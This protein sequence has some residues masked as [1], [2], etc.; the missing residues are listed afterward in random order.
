LL[1]AEN[2]KEEEKNGFILAIRWKW[3]MA[4][5]AEIE[6]RQKRDVKHLSGKGI[7]RWKDT[8]EFT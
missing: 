6:N 2:E 1:Y 8:S 7:E 4:A 3:E 5:K